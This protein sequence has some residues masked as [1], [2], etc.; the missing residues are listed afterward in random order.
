[1]SVVIAKGD[2]RK[3]LEEVIQELAGP[4]K[5]FKDVTLEAARQ[6]IR[7]KY[8]CEVSDARFYWVRKGFIKGA[9]TKKK[10]KS[11]RDIVLNRLNRKEEMDGI[12][13]LV[14][15]LKQVIAKVGKNEAKQLI[16]EL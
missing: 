3:F 12:A 1:M 10:T 15:A 7:E 16:D 4:E 6:K 9:R 13:A 8:G 5:K 11:V 2:K 14:R